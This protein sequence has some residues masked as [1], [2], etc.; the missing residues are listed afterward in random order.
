MAV[1]F[2]IRSS[3]VAC[4]S[5]SSLLLYVKYVAVYVCV[6][7]VNCNWSHWYLFVLWMALYALTVASYYCLLIQV[8]WHSCIKVRRA[9][10]GLSLVIRQSRLLPRVDWIGSSGFMTLKAD[11]YFK[12]FVTSIKSPKCT[13][14]L[15]GWCS[16]F[17]FLAMNFLTAAIFVY[18]IV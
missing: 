13:R 2:F 8:R 18:T 17:I 3:I 10:S 14:C 9:V 4:L 15:T 12:R 5:E 16:W 11:S 7:V 1:T 6:S